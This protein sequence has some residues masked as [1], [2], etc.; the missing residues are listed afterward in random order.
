MIYTALNT[1][2]LL[3]VLDRASLF[4]D[5]EKNKVLAAAAIQIEKLLVKNEMYEEEIEKIENIIQA[6]HDTY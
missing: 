6:I 5:E 3:G 2:E 1:E 4:T